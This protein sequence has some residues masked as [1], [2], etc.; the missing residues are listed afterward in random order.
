MSCIT[1]IGRLTPEQIELAKSQKLKYSSPAW[2]ASLSWRLWRLA[3]SANPQVRAA[4]AAHH[5]IPADLQRALHSDPSPVVRRAL[6]GNPY[7][8]PAL[9]FWL[10]RFDQDDEVRGR[11]VLNPSVT[12]SVVEVVSD[13]DKS[14]TIRRLAKWRLEA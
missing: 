11:A 3:R 1:A 7:V 9:L 4:A 13:L 8:Y 5:N 12:L 10:A 2:R 6:A 14:E